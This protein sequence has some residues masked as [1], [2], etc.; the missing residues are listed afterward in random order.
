MN[1]PN[2]SPTDSQLHDSQSLYQLIELERDEIDQS[3]KHFNSPIPK[4]LS[5]HYLDYQKKKSFRF[6][7]LINFLAL[8]AYCISAL[9]DYSVL[10]DVS[11]IQMIYRLISAVGFGLIF[12]IFF[13]FVKSITLLDL[14]LPIHICI[15][16]SIWF[17]LLSYSQ[18]PDLQSYKYAAGIFI[19]NACIGI[20]VNFRYA[21]VPLTIIVVMTCAGVYLIS[22]FDAHE[23][24]IFSNAYFPIVCFSIFISWN[25]TLRNRQNY[26]NALLDEYN[27]QTLDRMAHTDALTTLHNRRYFE[28]LAEQQLSYSRNEHSPVFLMLLDID[29]FKKINDNYGHDIGDEVLKYV[30]NISKR[31]IRP[32]DILA[33]FGGEE[34]I[35]LLPNVD[36]TQAE[37]IADRICADMR[38]NPFELDEETVV[39]VTSSI[40]Y[41]RFLP[42][43][44]SL[45]SLI[46]CADMALYVAKQ[47]GRDR[48]VMHHNP[49]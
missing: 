24:F 49:T 34:F 13:H 45:R 30:A 20:Q 44:H 46:K 18:S 47:Q 42:H 27:R 8:I 2:V 37:Q 10:G 14:F 32:E 38:K 35:I 23:L 40:G 48:V 31:N 16:I 5:K 1:Q 21:L 12:L 39:S 7:F 33:R 15:A 25:A 17:I 4:A 36:A 41:A 28:T 6:L 43:C 29:H 22:N 26:L 11:L 3:L 19:L 9:A